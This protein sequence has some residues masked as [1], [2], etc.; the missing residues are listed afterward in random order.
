MNTREA[1]FDKF[2]SE[3]HTPYPSLARAG[4]DSFMIKGWNL[5]SGT[6]T[7]KDMYRNN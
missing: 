4:E 5:L 7:C 2:L 1:M 3:I 6:V